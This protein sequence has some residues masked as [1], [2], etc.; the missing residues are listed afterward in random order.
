MVKG[1]GGSPIGAA[2]YGGGGGDPI[3]GGGGRGGGR[4]PVRAAARGVRQPLGL[5]EATKKVRL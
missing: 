4:W 5:V 2:A 1:G 3:G